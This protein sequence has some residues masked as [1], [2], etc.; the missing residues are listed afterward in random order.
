MKEYFTASPE[1][2]EKLAR[3]IA[4]RALDAGHRRLFL[5]LF[6]EMGV[7]KTAFTRGFVGAVA[8]RATVHS[9]TYT[10]VNEYRGGML[11]VFHFDMYRIEE[12]DELYSVGF[13]DYLAED[14]YILCEWSENIRDLLPGDA[15]SVTIER[16]GASDN[17]RKI[18]VKGE[19][20]EGL[21]P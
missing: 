21:M 20:Y 15:L 10:V 4:E 19:G 12:P 8:T 9:P 5:A 7:G 18:T 1:E 13:E 2:T 17:G 16:W 3:G 14:G 11:P 6:G